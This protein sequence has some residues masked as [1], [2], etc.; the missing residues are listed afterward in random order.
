MT[1]Q[2]DFCPRKLLQLYNMILSVCQSVDPSKK[3]MSC[4]IKA[5]CQELMMFEE[6]VSMDLVIL[7]GGNRF[8]VLRPGGIFVGVHVHR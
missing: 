5:L 6:P 8:G 4:E 3:A 2:I 7:G 1:L